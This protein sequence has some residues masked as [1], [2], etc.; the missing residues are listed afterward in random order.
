MDDVTPLNE[1]KLNLKLKLILVSN[2]VIVSVMLDFKG[3]GRNLFNLSD[4]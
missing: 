2:Q 3:K 4:S 1:E